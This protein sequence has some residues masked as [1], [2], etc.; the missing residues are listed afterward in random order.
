[1]IITQ[2]SVRKLRTTEGYNNVS[3]EATAQVKDGE[4]PEDV[5]ESLD[6]WVEGQITGKG[7]DELVREKKTLDW[8]VPE[9]KKEKAR[10]EGE[11]LQLR[12]RIGNLRAIIN[13]V[14]DDQPDMP[15]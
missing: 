2:V 12:E 5:R 6:L 1:M 8:M 3:I 15:F 9:M 4:T 14:N 11:V 7:H 10:L 13:K